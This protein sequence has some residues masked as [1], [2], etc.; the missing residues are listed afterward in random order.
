MGHL[1]VRKV[2][3]TFDVFVDMQDSTE[4]CGNY[5]TLEEAVEHFK[6]A[7]KVLNHYVPP[8]EDV[9][10]GDAETNMSWSVADALEYGRPKKSKVT[11]KKPSKP[12]SKPRD[13]TESDDDLDLDLSNTEEIRT[14]YKL[15][16]KASNSHLHVHAGASGTFY[17]VRNYPGWPGLSDL[18]FGI[19]TIGSFGS[20]KLALI[21]YQP[22]IDGAIKAIDSKEGVFSD[23]NVTWRLLRQFEVEEYDIIKLA[24][25]AKAAYETEYEF[26]LEYDKFEKRNKCYRV[27]LTRSRGAWAWFAHIPAAPEIGQAMASKGRLDAT[28]KFETQEE[29]RED[30]RRIAAENG[31]TDFE[32]DVSVFS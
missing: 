29:A 30:W 16:F 1:I 26:K 11:S 20:G 21:T 22:S 27:V 25:R 14:V 23:E 10:F 18:L 19:E 7:A 9:T 2:D 6:E 3:G 15:Q 32:V 24:E 17:L 12:K 28:A 13:A 5:P 31:I 4:K 8:M